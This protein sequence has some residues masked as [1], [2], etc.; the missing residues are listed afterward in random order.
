MTAQEIVG[1]IQERIGDRLVYSESPKPS[2]LYV[3]VEREALPDVARLVFE[4]LGARYVIGGGTDLRGQSPPGGSGED[5]DTGN[6][7]VLG[8][9]FLV[10][11]FLAFDRDGIYM[12]LH[13][14]VPENDP[15]VP[16]ITP[17]IPGANW[18][19]REIY[20]TVGV[21]AE[22][23][24][25][26][27]RLILPDDW[28]EGVFP[29]R[30]D[31]THDFNPP[32]DF[33]R[34][35][36]FRQPPDG[37]HV[38]P[39]GPFYP[40]LEE[41]AHFRVFVDGERVVGADYRGFYNHRGVEKLGCSKLTYNQIPFM[42]ERI[43]GICG[44]VHSTC[45]CQAM[46]EAA[47]IEVP[48]RAR[49]IRTI[50]LELERVH[51]HLLWTGIAGHIIGFDTVLMQTW[52][53]REPLMWLC[54]EITGN[55][56]TYG[57]NIVG[58]VRRDISPAAQKETIDVID[59]I[60]REWKALLSAIPGDTTL[61]ARVRGTCLLS[62]EDARA[63]CATGPT[64]RGSGIDIDVRTDHPYAAY[65]EIKATRKISYPQ[66]DILARV[67]VRLEETLV[68]IDIIRE[69]IETLP[70]GPIRAE[71]TEDIP[72]WRQG[73]SGV[74]APRGEVFHW[75]LTGGDN[76]P[77]RWRVRAP[78]YANLQN[79]PPMIMGDTLADVPIGIGSFDPCFSCT[80]RMEVVDVNSGEVKVYNHEEML[81][82]QG[83]QQG[84][85]E[86]PQWL[87]HDEDHEH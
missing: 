36:H 2:R 71:I 9:G 39:I 74:E 22:G 63:L 87:Y 62:K 11:H 82:L 5:Q 24:P 54:E 30:S 8:N 46:E 14:N 3:T 21:R 77:I 6:A 17:I 10:T 25:D 27:R 45:Y 29:L 41:P 32:A 47:G 80:E 28:P 66:C 12:A 26:P 18:A 59:E 19:E 49:W 67:L 58:G 37:A 44:F 52:R 55:R 7:P 65:G 81:R 79:V 43:C 68:A 84:R 60:E 50:L 85:P 33:S 31:Y 15:V 83:S 40:V 4:E 16:S 57:M 61:M 70:D 34:R 75:V 20:D 13:A 56:K 73:M 64:V 69:A 53:M 48:P 72:P 1:R 76:R 38:V 51:S 23:H 86:P 42:A 35:P 78:T